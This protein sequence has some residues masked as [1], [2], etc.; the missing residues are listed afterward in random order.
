MA[1]FL[2]S[3]ARG[4]CLVPRTGTSW[5]TVSEMAPASRSDPY[6][7]GTGPGAPVG[8]NGWNLPGRVG[9][10][11]QKPR[12]LYSASYTRTMA[13]PAGHTPISGSASGGN[14]G[15]RMGGGTRL[16]LW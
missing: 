6:S 11:A 7:T 3:V 13:F 16:L 10:P 2:R 14:G 8:V 9:G 4:T 15:T 5:N 12:G 1:S